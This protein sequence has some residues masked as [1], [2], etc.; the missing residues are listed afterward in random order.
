MSKQRV[1]SRAAPAA[2]ASIS[3]VDACIQR[4]GMDPSLIDVVK[5]LAAQI[6]GRAFCLDMQSKDVHRRDESELYLLLGFA[7]GIAV[8]GR[9]DQKRADAAPLSPDA[10]ARP[11]KFAGHGGSTTSSAVRHDRSSTAPRASPAPTRR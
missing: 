11:D 3:S 1:P 2:E 6:Y 8:S 5:M 9:S 7:L 10:S 4:C